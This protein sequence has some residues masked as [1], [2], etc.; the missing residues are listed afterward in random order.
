MEDE[1]EVA[2][3][4]GEYNEGGQIPRDEREE[5]QKIAHAET[6]RVQIWR[7]NVV[8]VVRIHQ[9]VSP[10]ELRILLTLNSIS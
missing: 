5:V 9:I 7:R 2:F 6:R 10:K 1:P 8:L 4:T 3:E